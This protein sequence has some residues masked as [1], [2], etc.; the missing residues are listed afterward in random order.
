MRLTQ[1]EKFLRPVIDNLDE[2]FNISK[3]SL[4]SLNTFKLSSEK[5][6]KATIIEIFEDFVLLKKLI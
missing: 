2:L 3:A 1:K 5:F 4:Q 6:I